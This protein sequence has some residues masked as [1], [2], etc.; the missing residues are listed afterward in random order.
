MPHQRRRK[1]M[2]ELKTD[3]NL[4]AALR[5]ASTVSLSWKELHDQRV[6]FIMG[7]LKESSEVTRAFVD[8]ELAKRDGR[9]QT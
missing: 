7:T 3:A 8:R 5:K 6:S 2:T 4:L 1:K 9:I